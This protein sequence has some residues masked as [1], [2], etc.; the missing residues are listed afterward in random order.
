MVASEEVM[1]PI[2]SRP[3]SPL[4]LGPGLLA[5]DLAESALR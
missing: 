5:V 1:K 2:E 4:P 3:K